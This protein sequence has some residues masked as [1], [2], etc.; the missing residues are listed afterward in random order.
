MATTTTVNVSMSSG[1]CGGLAANV[2][3]WRGQLG[4]PPVADVLTTPQLMSQMARRNW[5]I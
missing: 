3:R 4:L 1:D 2:N 5:W